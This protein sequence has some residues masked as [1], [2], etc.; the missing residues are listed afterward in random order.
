MESL[1]IA[2]ASDWFYPK[3]GGIE[4]H[5][6]EL[7]SHLAAA[8]HE[9]HVFTHDYRHYDWSGAEPG[10][11][12]IIHRLR[13]SVYMK[14]CHVSLG[15]GALREANRVYKKVGFD[16]T[17]VHSLYSP[18]AVAIANLSRGIRGVPVV[19]TNH[20][21][22]SWNSKA[23]RLFLPL[24]RREL[25]RIDAFIAVS[26]VV[27]EDTR[28]LLGRRLLFKPIH[29][30]PNAIEPGFWRPPEPQEREAARAKLGVPGDEPVVLVVGRFT[31]R[32]A[33]HEAPSI[34]Y[35]AARRAG[36]RLH[37][38]IIGDGPTRPLV[39]EEARRFNGEHLRVRILG[40]MGREELRAAYWAGDVLLLTS[41]MEAFSITA[42]EAMAAGVVAVGYSD[43]GV[44]DILGDGAGVL[45]RSRDEA[46]EAISKLVADTASLEEMR[47]RAVAKVQE[48]YSWETVLP[49]IVEIYRSVAEYAAAEDHEYL[50]HRLWLRLSQH[51]GRRRA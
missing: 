3:I 20:S 39:E 30:V 38:V 45:V 8:G 36:R 35:R 19:A 21:L 25:R 41:R 27:A 47:R 32:K 7:A 49:R 33:V 31:R 15:A 12:Y 11:P 9:V 26:S 44:R 48:E 4:T 16:I 6:D 17:H 28:R 10:R 14:C 24:L 42:L 40:F 22:F 1:K 34:V 2:V 23:A 43:S 18:L 37:L 5:I 13:G 29:V 46:A 51:L 50:L